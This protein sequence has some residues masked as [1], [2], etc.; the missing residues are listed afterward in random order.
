LG[1]RLLRVPRD[2]AGE[3]VRVRA[4][5]LYQ[6]KLTQEA[7]TLVVFVTFAFFYFG[8]KPQW[9]HLAAFLCI[10][11]AVAF[12]FLPGKRPSPRPDPSAQHPK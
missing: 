10:L 8:T 2:G 11:A 1:D 3:P 7:I 4:L 12:T 9:N 6:L 5:P